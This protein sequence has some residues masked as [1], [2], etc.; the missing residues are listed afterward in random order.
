MTNNIQKAIELPKEEEQIKESRFKLVS[1]QELQ[2][3]DIPERKH[4]I[5]PLITEG[6]SMEINGATGIGKTWFTLE[7][8]CSVASG[9]SFMGKY[10]V[11]NPRPVI[12]IDGEMPFDSIRERINL[13]MA[14]YMWQI[15]KPSDIRIHLSNP[16]LWEKENLSS[17]KINQKDIQIKLH[18]EI[19]ELSNHYGTP[20]FICFDNL[21]CLTDYKENDNDDWTKMLDFY[22]ILKTEGHSICHIHHVG[23][24]GDQRGAS[25]KHDALDTVIQLKRPED[26]D[27]SEGA[28]FNVK[29]AKHRHFAGEDARSFRCDIKVDNENKKVSWELS[30]FADI[31]TEEVLKVYCENLPD[32][33]YVGV[34]KKTGISKSAVARTIQH[35]VKNGLYQDK[36]KE[37]HGDDWLQ[38]DKLMKKQKKKGV[39]LSVQEEETETTVVEPF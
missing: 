18:R 14:R 24:G 1:L 6:S 5:K 13:I 29:F 37:I 20:L 3:L 25:R 4:I 30:D 2:S 32:I 23:K 35:C 17:P 28:V 21:S 31:S 16:F 15:K 34:E 22:T 33:T 36:M 9:Q 38:Y 26:Y 12:Y 8:I 19:K 27:A 11:A 7:M 10:T 39:S